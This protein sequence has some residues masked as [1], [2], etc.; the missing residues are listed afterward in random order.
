MKILSAMNVGLSV[1]MTEHFFTFTLS[2]IPTTKR[3]F[4][5][6]EEGKRDVR[7]SYLIA[8]GLSL[9]FSG[10]CS[11]LYKDPYGFLASLALCI[12]FIV[13]YERALRGVI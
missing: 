10:V 6:D 13:L 7:R 11:Y 9:L 5:N 12:F 2:S 3:F 8:T 4:S 1:I